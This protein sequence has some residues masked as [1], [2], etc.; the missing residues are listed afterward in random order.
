MNPLTPLKV[1][2]VAFIAIGLFHSNSIASI[3][4]KPTP[5][6]GLNYQKQL[7]PDDYDPA[8]PTP[9]SLLGFPVGQ[10]C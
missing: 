8:I 9:E 7:L 1:I 3:K 5:V 4:M 10:R 2:L 6:V